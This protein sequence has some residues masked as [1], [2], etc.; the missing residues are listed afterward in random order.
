MLN[1]GEPKL[2][3]HCSFVPVQGREIFV[4][5]IGEIVAS[6]DSYGGDVRWTA[7]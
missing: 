7:R 5:E 1:I 3:L 4:L 6:M 2:Q